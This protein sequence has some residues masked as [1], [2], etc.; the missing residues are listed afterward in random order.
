M[1]KIKYRIS[2]FIELYSKDRLFTPVISA[3]RREQLTLQM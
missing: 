2:Y 1:F 3:I